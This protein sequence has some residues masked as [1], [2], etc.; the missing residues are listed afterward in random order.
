[1]RE[2]RVGWRATVE[3]Q[4][5]GV[6]SDGGRWYADAPETRAALDL[7]VERQNLTH[8]EKTHWIEQRD[9]PADVGAPVP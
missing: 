7:I 6:F 8:G 9:D 1:M 3:H 5:R 4:E 2:I